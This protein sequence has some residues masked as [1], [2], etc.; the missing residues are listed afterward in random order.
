[1]QEES[2]L[3]G[4]VCVYTKTIMETGEVGVGC[5]DGAAHARPVNEREIISH[6][7]LSLSLVLRRQGLRS[8]LILLRQG[9]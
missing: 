6:S 3:R 7:S 1:M 9:K 4:R 8:S 5:H 2:I